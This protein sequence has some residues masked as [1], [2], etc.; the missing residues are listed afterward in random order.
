[1]Q[2]FP[3]T[4]PTKFIEPIFPGASLYLIIMANEEFYF[5]LKFSKSINFFALATPPASGLTTT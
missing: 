5:S 3:Y 4:V 2:F 1:M